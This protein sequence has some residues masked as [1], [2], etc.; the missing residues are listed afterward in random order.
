[1]HG[2]GIYRWADGRVYYG[3]LKYDKSDGKGYLRSADG[4]EYWGEYKK[5]MLWGE[6]VTQEKGVLYRDKYE[7]G[8]RMSR[9]QK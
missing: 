9:I 2:Y 3:E 6:G 8:K 7:K 5:G 1:M 4:D